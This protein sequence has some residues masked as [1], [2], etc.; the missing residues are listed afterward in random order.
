MILED[1][2]LEGKVAVITGGG[3]GLGKA[4]SHALAGAGADVV[5]AARRVGPIEETASEVRGM[6]RRALAIST[7]VAD[8]Q[9]VERM[10]ERAISELG[11]VDILINNAGI[12]GEQVTKPIWEITD[13][14]WRIGI[15]TNLTGA[16]YC[17]RAV[18]RHMVERGSGRVI[19][20]SS[21]YGLRGGRDNFMY[22]CAKAGVV[23]LTRSLALTWARD[24]V[25]VNCI[26]PG[27]F[28]TVPLDRPE[29]RQYIE[30][31][32]R[33]NP[34]GRVGEPGDVGPL[35]VFLA[36]EASDYVTGEIFCIDGGGLAGGYTPTGY[37]P[38]IPLKG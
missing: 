16:F 23:L 20:I 14:E 7:D 31:T 24:G 32:A 13:E 36:S 38:V 28:A 12:G 3:T 34:M 9:Q 6:G 33:F 15:D 4:M 5:V 37:A 21:G 10:V 22:C 1:L 30:S 35:A 8:S 17:S 18:G 25:R 19:N 29:I 26:V 2:N 11:K 27:F